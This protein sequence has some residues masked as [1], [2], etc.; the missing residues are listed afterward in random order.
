MIENRVTGLQDWDQPWPKWP[1]KAWEFK[2]VKAY[3]VLT[4]TEKKL[5]LCLGQNVLGQ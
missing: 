5:L 2:I 3:F 1:L 4:V